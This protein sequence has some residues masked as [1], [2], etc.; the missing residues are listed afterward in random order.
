M[1][2]LIIFDGVNP[3]FKIEC[4]KYLILNPQVYKFY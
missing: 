2:V 1:A 4:G 3:S